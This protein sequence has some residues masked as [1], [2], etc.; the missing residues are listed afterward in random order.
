MTNATLAIPEPLWTELSGWLDE[1]DEVAGIL[2]ARLI[3]DELGTTMLAGRLERAPEDAYVDRQRDGLSLRSVGWVPSVRRAAIEGEMAIFVHTHPG[4]TAEF[5]DRDDQVDD[6]LWPA[7]MPLTGVALYGAF[8]LAGLAEAPQLAGRLRRS[9]GSTQLL[10]KVRVVGNGLAIHQLGQTCPV[11][12]IHDRQLRALGHDGQQVLHGLRAGVVGV[13]GTGSPLAEQL[14]RLGV[15]SIVAID[16]DEVTPSTV[17]RGYGSAAKDVGRPKVDVLADHVERI[18][19]GTAVEPVHGNLRDRR[20]AERLRHCDVVFS[21]VDGHAARLVL[22]RW[23]YWHL[24]PVVDVAVLITSIGGTIASIDG[25]VTWLSP[26]TSCLLCRGRVDPTLAYAEQLDP[27]ERRRLAQQGYAPELEEP[28]P[29]VVTYTTLMAS[30]AATE[31]LNRLFGLAD[32]AP[33]ELLVQ[34]HARTTSMN[35]RRPRGGCFCGRPEAWGKGNAEPYLDLT[36]TP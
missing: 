18:G 16:D 20:V 34:L 19:L 21:C 32:T 36:W 15:G 11:E 29:S 14:I 22:N 30:I 9:D 27:D 24:A 10:T 28:Q 3:D 13:G 2:T 33:T 17:S 12:A 6:D 23:A 26:G 25:R 35:R 5:S 8:L 1:D 4:G 31:L 7:F